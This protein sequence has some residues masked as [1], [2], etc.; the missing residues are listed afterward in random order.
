[1]E[2]DSRCIKGWTE[3]EAK[4]FIRDVERLKELWYSDIQEISTRTAL[5]NLR[6]SREAIQKIERENE[7][8]RIENERRK[9]ERLRKIKEENKNL[10]WP[11]PDGPFKVRKPFEYWKNGC[12]YCSYYKPRTTHDYEVHVV[13][14]HPGKP[15]YPG[16][17]DLELYDRRICL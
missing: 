16:P 5:A 14:T 15:S 13:T 7:E 11:K 10:E 6:N 9:Q 17:A 1:M 2:Q 12:L 8:H 4:D 3:E